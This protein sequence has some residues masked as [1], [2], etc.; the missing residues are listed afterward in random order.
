MSAGSRLRAQHDAGCEA[1]GADS[2]DDRALRATCVHEFAHLAVARRFGACGFVTVQRLHVAGTPRA[3]WQGRFQLFGELDD[4][5]WRI[6][7]IAGTLAEQLLAGREAEATS[8]HRLLRMPGALSYCDRALARGFDRD[9]V[10]SCVDALRD[11]WRTIIG[12]ASERAEDI[13][14][15]LVS[16]RGRAL[17][18]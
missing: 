1:P 6:V 8:L 14:S 5:A 16:M 2:G 13:G 10:A 4:D 9:H 17:P 11:A 15:R 3:T 18:R 12:D 7:A